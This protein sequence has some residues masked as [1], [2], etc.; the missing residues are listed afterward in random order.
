MFLLQET[1]AKALTMG[2]RNVNLIL[3]AGLGKFFLYFV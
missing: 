2:E 1:G 3:P